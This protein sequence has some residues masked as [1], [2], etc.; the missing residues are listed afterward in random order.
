MMEAHNFVDYYKVLGMSPEAAAEELGRRF[1]RLAKRYHP[2]N[3]ATGDRE[4]FDLVIEAHN[5]LK[6]PARRA[7]YDV[8]HGQLT[9]S[10]AGTHAEKPSASFVGE[11]VEIQE[12]LLAP[13]YAR[14]RQ[15]VREPGVPE[16]ELERIFGCPVDRL[17]FHLWYL[18]AKRWIERL[19]NGMYGI[20]IEG[21]DHLNAEH[22]RKATTR[23]LMDH[24]EEDDEL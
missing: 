21:V 8:L 6:D 4:R 9:G 17:E 16:F 20:T 15:N 5:M 10:Q 19:D 23:L 2:D 24:S 1:H 3:P 14:R 11:D 22:H 7:R 18:K 12:K 13:F